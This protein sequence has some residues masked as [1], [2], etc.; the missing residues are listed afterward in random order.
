[1][2][3]TRF[4][5]TFNAQSFYQRIAD[6]IYIRLHKRLYPHLLRTLW[7]DRWLLSG[8]DVSTAAYILNDTVQTV[9]Q[10]Y[11]ELRSADHIQKAYAFNQAIL[12]NRKGSVA[13]V[14][15]REFGSL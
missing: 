11:H 10:R 15:F 5:G 4:G 8:G 12:T 2:F 14:L 6:I 9:L 3:P 13:N 7:V 1:V